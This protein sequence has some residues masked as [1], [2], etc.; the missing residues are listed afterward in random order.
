MINTRFLSHP[1]FSNPRSR[2]ILVSFSVT[3]IG[4]SLFLWIKVLSI[5]IGAGLNI[6]MFRSMTA[7][8]A[9]KMIISP[10]VQ[11]FVVLFSIFLAS[12]LTAMNVV[13]P[14]KRLEEWLMDWDRGHSLTPLKSRSGDTYDNLIHLINDLYLVKKSSLSLKK[15]H[16]A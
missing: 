11:L 7:T 10:Y 4:V 5:L 15:H 9:L 16:K 6:E 12:A 14:V 1:L 13:G 8:P 3:I 2:S